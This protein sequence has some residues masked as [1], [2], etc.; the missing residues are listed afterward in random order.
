MINRVKSRAAVEELGPGVS[1]IAYL[2]TGDREAARATARAG[3]A[4]VVSKGRGR[5]RRDSWEDAVL[6][7]VV[8]RTIT[9]RRRG[10]DEDGRRRRATS[11]TLG[12]GCDGSPDALWSAFQSLPPRERAVLVLRYYAKRT[13]GDIAHLLGTSPGAV[14]SYAARGLDRLKESEGDHEGR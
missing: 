4:E 1:A 9:R 13:D 2:V 10:G 7:A 8:R 5:T 3:L 14:S 11:A 12:D 6:R